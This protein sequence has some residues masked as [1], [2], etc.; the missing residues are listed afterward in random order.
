M[1]D[2]LL[3]RYLDDE[4]DASER[5]AVDALDPT[6]PASR[7]LW[8]LREGSRLFAQTAAAVAVPTL[9]A[10]EPDGAP[11]GSAPAGGASARPRG[12]SFWPALRAASLAL[13][14][15]TGTAAAHPT[16]RAAMIRGFE[17]VAGMLGV[18]GT[19]VVAEEGSA[20]GFASVVVPV[21]GARFTVE[22][23][24]AQAAGEFVV[25]R[26]EGGEVVARVR[27]AELVVLP[28]GLRVL[29]GTSDTGDLEITVPRSVRELVLVVDGAE[30][31]IPLAAGEVERRIP[32]R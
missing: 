11:A 19:A 13:A 31:V 23:R 18:G 12:S 14:V 5:A 17:A 30:T 25:L 16:S 21:S 15:V 10:L 6:D 22:V 2:E 3:V 7:R 8:E 32:L 28:T 4:V 26:G 1:N 27:G 9:P 24:A 20:P 29:N